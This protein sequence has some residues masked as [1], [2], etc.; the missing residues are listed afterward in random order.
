MKTDG[1]KNPFKDDK[2]GK[3]WY[4]AFMKRHP[5]ISLRSPR[6]LGKERAVIRA[7]NVEKW[8]REFEQYVETST[9]DLDILKDPSRMYNADESGF[10]LCP[11]T[12]SVLGL[13]GVKSVYNLV[14]SDK[15]QIT[16]LAGMSAT[17]HYLRPMIVFPGQRFTKNMLDGFD[18]A[19]MGRSENGWMDSEL[20]VEWLKTVFI[21]D[22]N[23]RQVKRPVI[24]L[25]DGH[26]THMSLEASDTCNENNIIL[27]C[28]LEHASHLMQ[29]CD[30]QLFGVL[31]ETWKTSIREWQ[32]QHVGQY[33][34]KYE[35]SGIFKKAWVSATKVEVAVKGFRDAGLFPLDRS[36]IL[37]TDK[38]QT[39]QLFEASGSNQK[40][41]FEDKA[42]VTGP[43]K[44]PENKATKADNS[45]KDNTREIPVDEAAT[46]GDNTKGDTI[47]FRKNI[48]N[49]FLKLIWNCR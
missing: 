23:T 41:S 29:P 40:K 8:F 6:Q 38:L 20:F 26:K 25:V 22:I 34:T 30:L 14:A 28:L 10:S 1:R 24:L 48:N 31:K 46:A 3:D 5:E 18:E 43:T 2:P 49:L 12:G 13:R 9:G 19:V 37:K 17:A 16:V 4:Y 45:T 44:I 47:P 42:I 32:I 15:T 27:Y 35:F 33:V 11:K 7:E 21:P 36:V 39:S